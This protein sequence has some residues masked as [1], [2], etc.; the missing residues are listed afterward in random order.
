M[1]NKVKA[2]VIVII[3]VVVALPMTMKLLG[4]EA[5]NA[6]A[7]KS[8]SAPTVSAV[9]AGPSAPANWFLAG[10]DARSY[11]FN[12]DETQGTANGPVWWYRCVA[13]APKGF[14][15]MMREMPPAEYAGHRVKMSARIKASGVENWAGMW[16]RVDGP[17]GEPL[18]FDNMQGRPIKGTQDWARYEIVLNVPPQS[19]KIAFGVL[20]DGRGQTWLSDLQFQIVGADVPVTGGK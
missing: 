1:E 15:T 10:K 17:A 13:P 14:G 18:A 16:M 3:T 20:L 9:A 11:A 4:F 8:S 19:A 12:L 5:V 7:G 6:Q 2:V